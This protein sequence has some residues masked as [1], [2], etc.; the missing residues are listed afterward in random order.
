MDKSILIILFAS[1]L[2]ATF[3]ALGMAIQ[4]RK[5]AKFYREQ[6]NTTQQALVA[7]TQDRIGLE[8]RV[9]VLVEDCVQKQLIV[10]VT[11]L[12]VETPWQN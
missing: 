10:R 1:C 9:K 12:P 7:M 11:D 4:A 5:E 3:T 8:R 2:T 6:L